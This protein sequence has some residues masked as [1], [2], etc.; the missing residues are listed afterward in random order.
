MD[1]KEVEV[2]SEVVNNAVVRMPDRTYLGSVIQGDALFLLHAEAMDL[3]E[4]LKHNPGNDAFLTAFSLAKSLEQRLLHYID[5]CDEHGIQ[6]SFDIISSVEDYQ[7][8]I[9]SVS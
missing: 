3:V 9:D 2:F 5:V 4:E 8:L 7:D 1:V 6:L